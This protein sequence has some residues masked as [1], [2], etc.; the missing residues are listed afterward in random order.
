MQCP[1]CQNFAP[2]TANVCGNCGFRLTAPT[3]AQPPA[4]GGLP[5][6]LWGI[7]GAILTLL[8]LVAAGFFYLTSRAQT[9]QTSAPPAPPPAVI[10]FPTP[11]PTQPAPPTPTP[12]S[13]APPVAQQSTDRCKPFDNLKMKYISLDWYAGT[14]LTFYVRMPGGVPG[15]EK[16]IAGDTQ[17]WNYSVEIGD[18]STDNCQFIQGYGERLY[19]SIELPS[20]YVFTLKPF[21]LTVD[22]CESPIYYDQIAEVPAYAR[23]PGGGGGGGGGGG[24]SCGSAPPGGPNNCSGAYVT[25]CSCMGGSYFCGNGGPICV[26]P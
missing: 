1:N 26:I 19:C 16:K 21:T 14:P 7:I 2:D 11:T 24:S 6:W 3:T 20:T 18:Y 10:S 8:I 12:T 22:G 9:A 23:S 17:P 4:T 13:P 15:L 5:G 25:W